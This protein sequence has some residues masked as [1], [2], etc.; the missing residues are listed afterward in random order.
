MWAPIFAENSENIVDV[1]TAYIGNLEAMKQQ[2]IDK[3]KEALQTTMHEVNKIKPV[4][5]GETIKIEK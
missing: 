4:L 1:L 5:D 2:I 3:N